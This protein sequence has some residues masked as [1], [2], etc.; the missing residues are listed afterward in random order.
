[1]RDAAQ[2]PGSTLKASE[3]SQ[4]PIVPI[5][6]SMFKPSID[7]SKGQGRRPWIEGSSCTSGSADPHLTAKLSG[8]GG[9][10]CHH[11]DWLA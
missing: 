10:K 3:S 7:A 2:Q 1:M 5:A 4:I 6:L 8:G 9:G 11:G